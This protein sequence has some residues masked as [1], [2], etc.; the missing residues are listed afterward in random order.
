MMKK[1][2]IGAVVLMA[3][4]FR[5]SGNSPGRWGQIHWDPAVGRHKVS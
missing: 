2:K 5:L 4:V 3:A 1:T